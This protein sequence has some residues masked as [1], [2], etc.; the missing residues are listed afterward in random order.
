MFTAGDIA[1]TVLRP[2]FGR[3]LNLSCHP[4][5]DRIWQHAVAGQRVTGVAQQ[6]ELHGK[7]E[8]I[9]I[10]PSLTDQRQVGLVE[11]VIADQI[12]LAFRQRKQSL[13]LRSRE[14][15]ATGHVSVIRA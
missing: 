11:G 9:G 12:V 10:T 4:L 7:A 5:N 8:T 1:L 3:S 6:A 13:A 14:Y 2:A 15:R